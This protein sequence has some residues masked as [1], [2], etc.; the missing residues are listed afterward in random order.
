MAVAHHPAG[1]QRVRRERRDP[2]AD[3]VA[4]DPAGGAGDLL[5][6][7]GF[8]PDVE[9]V[10][11]DPDR[12]GRQRLGDVE[13]L[14][15]GGHDTA[16]GGEDRV[17]RLDGQAYADVERVRHQR[18][19]RRGR[20]RARC[21]EV[22]VVAGKPA[23]HQHQARRTELRRL[24][25]RAPVVVVAFAAGLRVGGGEEAAPADR[26]DPQPRVAHHA[27]GI[28]QADLGDGL[29][30]HPERGQPVGDAPGDRVGERPR[31]DGLLVQGEARQPRVTGRGGGEPGR[32]TGRDVEGCGDGHAHPR[33][34]EP[35]PEPVGRQLRVGQQPGVVRQREQ[36]TEMHHAA[37]RLHPADH[38]EARL[39]AGEPGQ[40]GDAGLVVPG[41]RL[42]DV[43]RQRQRRC[44]LGVV[45]RQVALV[46]CRQGR[47]R[48]RGHGRERTQQGVAVVPAVA[49]DQRRVVE[50]VAGVEAYAVRQVGPQPDLVVGRQQRDLHPVDLVGVRADQVEERRR[51]GIGV[52]GAPVAAQLRVEGL[53]QPVQDDRLSH[54]PEQVG[55]TR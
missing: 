22:A 15:Q 10:D 48:G 47:R 7:L 19:D 12:L 26:R 31:V 3:L 38:G 35:D 2:L 33:A 23:R 55:R 51:R 6:D 52:D 8:P 9:G 24:V 5:L 34:L 43:T 41:R 44:H 53:A 39:V 37:R 1:Q 36:P 25:E 46:E 17:H 20:S 11:H 40:E 54:L 32:G 30:P 50:V 28:G 49:T 42:E 21:R 45:R 13:R 16:V 18:L 4:R 29:S 14:P 27:D